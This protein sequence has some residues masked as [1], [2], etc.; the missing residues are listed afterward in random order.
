M[1]AIQT[2]ID[3]AH[4][5]GSI[6]M[7]MMISGVM[8]LLRDLAELPFDCLWGVEPV[9]GVEDQRV[10]RESLPGKSMFGGV[11]GPEHLSKGTPEN[12][13]RGVEEAFKIMGKTGF[14]LGP[15]TLFRS[16][17]SWENLAAFENAW[18]RLRKGKIQ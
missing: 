6:Y 12:T 1:P 18:K 14:I 10:V 5:A 7:Y 4:S 13:V 15:R 8:P 9:L 2:E 16:H 11:S 17:W 3:M